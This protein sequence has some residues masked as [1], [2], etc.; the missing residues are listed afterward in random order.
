MVGNTVAAFFVAP[1]RLQVSEPVQRYV[2]DGPDA[3][4]PQRKPYYVARAC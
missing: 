4:A 2:T 3:I 1:Q